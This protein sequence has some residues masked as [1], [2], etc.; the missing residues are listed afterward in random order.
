MTNINNWRRQ[1]EFNFDPYD[2]LIQ[3]KQNQEFLFNREIIHNQMIRNLNQQM[4]NLNQQNLLLRQQIDQMT[5]DIAILKLIET[6]RND[7][8]SHFTP[9]SP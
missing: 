9:I 7:Q 1:M 6:N 2:A 5:Y 4:S 3:L 8:I